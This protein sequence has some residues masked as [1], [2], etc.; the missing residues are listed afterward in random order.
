MQNN[1]I[2]NSE[3]R[4]SS[5]NFLHNSLLVLSGVEVLLEI[6]DSCFER[7]RS[8]GIRFYKYKLR[9]CDMSVAM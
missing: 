8:I 6:L 4:R 9:R 2:T 7:R 3:V 1:R 5:K